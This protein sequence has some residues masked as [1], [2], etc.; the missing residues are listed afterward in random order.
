M[1]IIPNNPN[2]DFVCF[3]E[4]VDISKGISLSDANKIDKLINKY[5]VV[6]FRDQLITDEQQIEF[7][8]LFGKIEKPGNNSSIQKGKDRRLSSKMADVSNITKS[9]K[10]NGKNDPTRIF[11][12]GNRL[13]HSDSSYKKIPA[14]YSLLS[15]RT[16]AKKGGNTEF[17][18]MRAAYD[19][20]DKNLKST[21]KD[22][23]CELSLIHI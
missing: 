3:I 12:L 9:S 2:S 6:V 19:K 8:E 1:K 23:V 20:L 4:G 22:M 11:N 13:W 15:A 16:V 17:A 14:K 5:A 10:V 18:D 7:T 21:I